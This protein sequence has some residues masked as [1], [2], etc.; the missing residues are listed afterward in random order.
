MAERL[1][2]HIF[3][4]WLS[5]WAFA[6]FQGRICRKAHEII[7]S[8][9]MSSDSYQYVLWYTGVFEKMGFPLS[10]DLTILDLGCGIG[11]CVRQFRDAGYTALGCDVEFPSILS[12]KSL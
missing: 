9:D 3:R 7:H 10:K 12:W 5:G 6:L 4:E 11:E 1:S 8:H 2:T